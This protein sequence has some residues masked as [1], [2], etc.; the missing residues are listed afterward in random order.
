MAENQVA[1]ADV[2][3]DDRKVKPE[4]ADPKMRLFSSRHR[5]P[6]RP[7]LAPALPALAAHAP[8]APAPLRPTQR[9]IASF[10]KF[11]GKRGEDVERFAADFLHAASV[12]SIPAV[13]QALYLAAN[14]RN[15]ASSWL[16]Q[17]PAWQTTDIAD[18][19]A[20]LRRHFGSVCNTE[21]VVLLD[22]AK[23]RKQQE[24]ETVGAFASELLA[25]FSRAGVSQK[26]DVVQHFIINLRKPLRKRVL[27]LQVPTHGT[28]RSTP[29]SAPKKPTTSS[30]ASLLPTPP[31]PLPPQT[32]KR[33]ARSSPRRRRRLPLPLA[34]LCLASSAA[35]TSTPPTVQAPTLAAAPVPAPPQ[36][37]A[38]LFAGLAALRLEV[39][40]LR[41]LPPSPCPKCG[42]NHWKRDCPQLAA[43]KGHAAEAVSA[44]ASQATSRAIA[45]PTRRI[46]TRP[47]H[48]SSRETPKRIGTR[49]SDSAN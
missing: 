31:L 29:P 22:A 35:P 26:D 8:A 44:V 1:P 13:G 11:R 46:A 15:A 30:T 14:L 17:Q 20:S 12:N 41:N 24:T 45:P 4:Q 39:A 18:L 34:L 38:E 21:R 3:A 16:Q 19:L 27:A 2:P 33:S 36:Y 9:L 32:A 43:N 28:P 48:P 47:P 10:P 49:A 5:W 6:L 42:G 25:A 23:N 7:T 40:A 37:V